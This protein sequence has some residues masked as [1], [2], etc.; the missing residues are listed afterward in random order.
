MKQFLL[1]KVFS[2]YQR[3]FARRFFARWNRLLF[4]LSLRGLGVLNYGSDRLTGERDFLQRFAARR[5]PLVVLDVGANEGQYASTLKTLAPAAIIYAFEPH[6]RTYERLE[7][8]AQ[9]HK[10]TAINLACGSK[11]DRLT[12]YDYQDHPQGSQHASLHQGVI[13]QIHQGVAA[14]W[15]VEVITIDD[16]L[17]QER[18]DNVDLLKIDTEGHEYEVLLGAREAI[19][20]RS[21]EIIHIEFNEMNV[22]SRVFCRDFCQLLQDYDFYRMLPDGLLPLGAYT[23]LT[24]ELF[25]YQ[26]LVAILRGHK[27]EN[28]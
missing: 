28:A 27:Q 11:P 14:T 20:R 2:L 24:W 22:I 7:D 21:I 25:A 12:L 3:I 17:K 13:E 16:F 19:A 4:Q 9:E 26:N 5:G 15:N 1:N 10:F 18:L 6:P 23:A 8:R